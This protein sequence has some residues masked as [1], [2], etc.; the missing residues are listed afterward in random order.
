MP[1]EDAP[2][3]PMPPPI[4]PEPPPLVFDGAG[5]GYRG[6][7]KVAHD[8]KTGHFVIHADQYK[9]AKP[10]YCAQVTIQA[11][12]YAKLRAVLAS[13]KRP[14]GHYWYY[15]QLYAV[16]ADANGMLCAASLIKSQR[17]GCPAMQTIESGTFNRAFYEIQREGW[18]IA[19]L[20]R[21]SSCA[22][23]RYRELYWDSTH[24]T[25]LAMQYLD[26]HPGG[27]E[28]VN[29]K[30]A[31]QRFKIVRQRAVALAKPE[32]IALKR[33]AVALQPEGEL[34]HAEENRP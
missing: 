15:A 10:L 13:W 23:V 2:I 14:D 22:Y 28:I 24:K 26:L 11:A 17:S 12:L 34:I 29:A 32:P 20:W 19:A 16:G 30:Q 8:K 7:R 18:E 6:I 33:P 3:A 4:I 9:E 5:W 31:P 27:L 21:V 25:M 1:P